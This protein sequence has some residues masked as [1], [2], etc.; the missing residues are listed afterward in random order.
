MQL[1]AFLDFIPSLHLRVS[2]SSS[3]LCLIITN[4]TLFLNAYYKAERLHILIAIQMYVPVVVNLRGN[5]QEQRS[6]S[7]F[8]QK[9]YSLN[10]DVSYTPDVPLSPLQDSPPCKTPAFP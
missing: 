10:D 2:S 5:G 8:T 6:Q 9:K 7:G 4:P 1:C 3:H